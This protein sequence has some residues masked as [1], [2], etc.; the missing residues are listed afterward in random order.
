MVFTESI[1][2][3]FVFRI[4]FYSILFEKKLIQK[5]LDVTHNPNTLK[6]SQ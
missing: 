1:M 2:K 4:L 3:V 6:Q 5:K